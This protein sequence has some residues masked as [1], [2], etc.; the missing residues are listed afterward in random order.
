VYDIDLKEKFSRV[1]DL[2]LP[3]DD[4]VKAFVVPQA[5][6]LSGTYFLRLMLQNNHGETVSENFY[7][8]S[9]RDDVLNWQ[10]S[11]WWYTPTS[12]YADMTQ[13]QKLQP[14]KL[15]VSGSAMRRGGEEIAHLTVSNPGSSLAFF[16][17]LQI[18]AGHGGKE[19]LPV[20]W[21]DNYFSLLPGESRELTGSYKIKD[22]QGA[23]SV[24]VESWNGPSQVVPLSRK[25]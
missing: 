10:R 8:L 4:N 23:T 15:A 21:Q 3:A 19:V 25:R 2:D 5:P 6:D 18:K 1:I 22:V 16:I 11:A 9:T 24:D 12:S 17:H 14:A 7:W 13:L 20:I